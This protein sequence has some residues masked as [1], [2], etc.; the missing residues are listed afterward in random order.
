[1]LATCINKLDENMKMANRLNSKL[2]VAIM[3]KEKLN[4]YLL[5]GEKVVKRP[6]GLPSFPIQ[7]QDELDCMKKFLEDNNNLSAA[8]SLNL[9]YK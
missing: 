7:T 1:M 2:D 3:N 4:R 8:V 9:S 5:P 6:S